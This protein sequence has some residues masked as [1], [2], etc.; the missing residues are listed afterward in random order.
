[1]IELK[2][3]PNEKPYTIFKSFYDRALEA[4]QRSIEAINISSYDAK[5]LMVDSRIVNLK[6]I[7]GNEWVFFSNY[8]SPKAKQFDSHDQIST[9]FFWGNINTQIRTKSKICKTSQDFSDSHFL[10]RT[11]EK[12]ALAI[13]S[14]QSKYI[15]SYDKVRENYKNSLQ[16]DDLQQ[17]PAYWGG[18]S[19]TPYYF[20]FWEGH[21]SRLNKR[22]IYEK[23]DDKWNHSILEP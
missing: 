7:L 2:N 12:N 6:Y 1:M 22:H 13:S 20:E 18:Y 3:T 23:Q 21:E 10:S 4:N 14:N 11:H 16:K 9:V 15:S 19:F 17:R 8:N 5:N